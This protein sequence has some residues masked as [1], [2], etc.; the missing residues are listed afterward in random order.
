MNQIPRTERQLV[1][2]VANDKKEYIISQSSDGK[3]FYLYLI[4]TNGF[5][6]I[7]SAT[8]PLRF[9]SVINPQNPQ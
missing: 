5:D 8:S 7:A 6:R 3:R 4:T 9:D 2:Q 1:H